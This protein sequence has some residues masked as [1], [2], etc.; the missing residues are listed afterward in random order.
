MRQ[1]ICFL[2]ACLLAFTPS[3]AIQPSPA[4][5]AVS[6][7]EIN[8]QMY[9]AVG[10]GIHDDTTAIQSALTYLSGAGGGRLVFPQGTY[11]ITAGLTVGTNTTLALSNSTIKR[12][13]A[14]VSISA[15][16]KTGVSV[17]N[18]TL[19]NVGVSFTSCTDSLARN[20][21]MKNN[22]GTSIAVTSCTSGLIQGCSISATQNTARIIVLS[23]SSDWR[24][25]S[26]RIKNATQFNGTTANLNNGIEFLGSTKCSAIGN[27][28]I[29]VGGQGII[30]DYNSTGPV[31]VKQIV[32]AD[33]YCEGCAQEG[34]TV[35]GGSSILA[36]QVTISG[37]VCKDNQNDAIEV[38]QAKKV[39]LTGNYLDNGGIGTDGSFG[40][41]NVYQSD[42]VNVV[43]N[44][45]LNAQWSGIG[46]TTS[47]SHC[48]C[49][50]NQIKTWDTTQPAGQQIGGVNISNGSFVVVAGN[51]F[52]CDYAAYNTESGRSVVG[53]T[54]YTVA[55]TGTANTLGTNHNL[56][57]TAIAGDILR[58]GTSTEVATSVANVTGLNYWIPLYDHTTS[59]VNAGRRL[60]LG[61]D[62]SGLRWVQES[63]STIKAV[64]D[65]FAQTAL[66][67]AK[68]WTAAA[69]FTNNVTING[70]LTATGTSLTA[71]DAAKVT[72]GSLP[73]ARLS[74]NVPLINGT[75]KFTGTNKFS[76]ALLE[77]TAQTASV[78]TPA[79]TIYTWVNNND[80]SSE[81]QPALLYVG[82]TRV[83]DTQTSFADLVS[84]ISSTNAA[85]TNRTF[86]VINSLNSGPAA[87]RTYSIASDG[88][89]Q[90][91]FGSGTYHIR[92]SALHGYAPY[93]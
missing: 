35:F 32:I 75:N 15:T 13:G 34:I 42:S 68:T 60:Y 51:T 17:E 84:V 5:A 46:F 74:A 19:D 30:A 8:A 39:T 59:P 38:W 22:S 69:T 61:V 18:G 12:T 7:V 36:E 4:L 29:N 83:T 16:S 1:I 55:M 23:G 87:A 48:L 24:V 91:A 81:P 20:L 41:I 63:G 65:T 28:V 57:T 10:N 56:N 64:D 88:S 45:V 11:L 93:R 9:G 26:N 37:N 82:G 62:G 85:F 27:Q 89:L 76:N 70:T 25:I 78:A 86:V 73:D 54:L 6:I 3:V 2:L 72:T 80:V 92:V 47:C 44:T 43:G 90:V 77:G 50:G 52:D 58:S 31:A 40:L 53:R 33:N 49:E 21:L 66:G 79:V 14:Q 71:L 67:G